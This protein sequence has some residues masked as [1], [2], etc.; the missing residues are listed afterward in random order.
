MGLTVADIQKVVQV[1][2]NIVG[3]VVTL[4]G[5]VEAFS[6][7]S[8]SSSGKQSEGIT[9]VVGGVGIIMVGN[10]LIPKMF[11]GL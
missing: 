1:I 5:A 9:K 11:V 4:M 2:I 10:F 8:H 6:G 7:Y 3:G